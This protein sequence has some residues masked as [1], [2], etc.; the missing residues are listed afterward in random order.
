MFKFFTRLSTRHPL[1][2]LIFWSLAFAGLL[3]FALSVQNVLKG[4]GFDAEKQEYYKARQKIAELFGGFQTELVLVFDIPEGSGN[5]IFGKVE[6]AVSPLRRESDVARVM[7]YGSS[8]DPR[9]VSADRRHTIAIVGFHLS[10]FALQ[11]RLTEFRQKIRDSGL[12]WQLTG[13]AAFNE[14][15]TEYSRRDAV[16]GEL[17]A[18]PLV[19]LV[20]LWLFRSI[21]AAILP[22]AMAAVSIVT[23]LGLTWFLG[24]ATDLSLFVLNVASLLG[25]GLAID[26]SLL[27]VSRYRE[28]YAL[29]RGSGRENGEAADLAIQYTLDTAG[30]AVF[31]S[32][33]TVLVGLSAM[34]LF[35]FMFMTSIGIGGMA[36]VALSLVCSLTLLPAC[37]KLLGPALER[38]RL[39]GRPADRDTESSPGLWARLSTF[40]L[41]WPLATLLVT[42]A[43]LL[44]L[45]SPAIHM[46]LGTSNAEILPV[47]SA[48]RK[49]YDLVEKKFDL[50]PKSGD[51]QI[52]VEPL[53]GATDDP[54]NLAA[55]HFF[56]QEL[57]ADFSVTNLVSPVNLG[58]P[59]GLEQVLG[60][61]AMRKAMPTEFDPMLAKGLDALLRTNA[62]LYRVRTRYAVGEKD[63][64]SFVRE[65]RGNPPPGLKIQVTG[66][67]PR[68]MDFSEGLYARFPLAA[69]WIILLT[70]LL[71]LPMFR[72]VWLPIKSV[73]STIL[74][75][76]ATFGI[77]VWIFQD[78]HLQKLLGFT[79]PTYTEAVLPAVLFS[80]LFGLS[81]DYEVFLLA[82]IREA[83]KET[84]DNDRAVV[85]GV[86]RTTG[87][88]TGAALCMILVACGFALA[89]I[90]PVKVIGV[91]IAVAVAVDATIVRGLLVPAVMKLL[92]EWNWWLPSWLERILPDW[93]GH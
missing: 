68:L 79:S 62:A 19:L 78:G 15:L 36:V 4:G 92:G 67:I 37:L 3:P 24:K 69:T 12:T 50:T 28:E 30:R 25:I 54:E 51:L 20:L 85:L 57:L 73:L 31:F 41:R 32:A 61:F 35:G 75:L 14:S 23:T 44:S 39:P 1:A 65:L 22:I 5:E 87:L 10:E 88:I 89:H 11:Q 2:V 52:L 13:A 83:W 59:M 58:G 91:G 64:E 27:I 34:T 90:L 82:R 43:L 26:Y 93:K 16:R 9:F 8:F 47:E 84:G 76:A 74:S 6:E 29:A 63:G 53:K 48:P 60:L 71:M 21:P 55:L 66:E 33:L 40:V 49:T 70:L 81:M 77:V 18:I 42:L 56:A 80:V 38:W 46:R 7:T 17:F 86:M 72:S 45:G